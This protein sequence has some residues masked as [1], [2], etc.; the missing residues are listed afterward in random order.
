MS[1]TGQL[2]FATG[3][4]HNTVGML[5]PKL[6][7]PLSRILADGGHVAVLDDI[8]ERYASEATFWFQFAGYAMMLQ[9]YYIYHMAKVLK[10]RGLKEQEAEP[11]SLG[12][13]ITLIGITGAYCMP[14]SGFHLVY[15]QGLR[16]LWKA[17]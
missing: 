13:A 3:F 5:I 12:W 2:F 9:G 10:S 7:E 15:L 17:N 4:L 11:A 16:I 1:L 8:H 14:V 6:A